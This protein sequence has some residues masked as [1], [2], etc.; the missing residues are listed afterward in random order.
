[1]KATPPEHHGAPRRGGAALAAALTLAAATAACAPTVTNHGHRLDA[2]LV[3]QIRPGVTS[4][5]EVARLLGS[6]SSVGAF[7]GQ[8]WYYVSQKT[9]RR[10]F[11]QASVAAQDVVRI[12]FDEGGTVKDVIRRGLETARAVDP[13]AERTRTLGNELTLVQQFLGNIGRFNTTAPDMTSQQGSAAR[14]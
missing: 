11:Y 2:D 14:R 1:M 13:S 7:D 9:E 6:P 4:R 3:A 12:D 5:D 8:S 10:S